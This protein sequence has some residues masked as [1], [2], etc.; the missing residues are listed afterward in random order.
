MATTTTFNSIHTME[1]GL[2][3]QRQAMNENGSQK[4]TA[5]RRLLIA[6]VALAVACGI[7][8]MIAAFTICNKD[9]CVIIPP[10]DEQTTFNSVL[11]FTTTGGDTLISGPNDWMPNDKA[12]SGEFE[13][14]RRG[15]DGRYIAQ[16][17][18][19]MSDPGPDLHLVFTNI[20]V[21]ASWT[22]EDAPDG[23]LTVLLTES[24]EA[25]DEALWD[26][27]GRLSKEGNFYQ[28][29]PEEFDP[30]DWVMATVWCVQLGHLFGM[31]SIPIIETYALVSGPNDW[32]PNDRDVGGQLE[33]YRR[34]S[35][36][37]YIA[38]FTDFSSDEGPD[39][40]L[41]FT[42]IDVDAE[43]TNEDAPEDSLVVLL[44]E[45]GDE[46]DAL[47]DGHGRLSKEG[48]FY[49]VLPAEYSPY[50]YEMATVWCI[51]FGHLFSMVDLQPLNPATYETVSGSKDW[52]P[53]DKTVSG[54]FELVKRSTDGRYIAQ[55]TD[56]MSDP[57]PDLHLVFTN[58]AVDASWTNEYV[59]DGS[60][61]VLLTESG[62][63]DD[64]GLWDGHGR[65]SKEGNF[66]QVLPEDFDPD[67]WVMATNWC[68]QLGHLFGMVEL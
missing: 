41:V 54:D 40:H 1:N 39:L 66:Y 43:W 3:Q 63:A 61:I 59:P 56:F 4:R 28:V 30:E 26:G 37:R 62:E 7:A 11:N 24:G 68:V 19:F 35:D 22:N 10:N 45:S 14:Y 65:L 31:V 67:D 21:D 25:D 32:M 2:P 12:V 6:G 23:S 53:N 38:Q 16:F 64:G 9:F 52:Q 36:N 49:Q 55:F 60:L 5:C 42:T 51:K 57:G 8:F 34:N 48:S 44:T 47:W 13:I 29:L 27:H 15:S 33:I 46:G 20:A 17:T 18:D 50:D 58:I